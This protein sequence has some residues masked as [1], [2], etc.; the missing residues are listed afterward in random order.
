MSDE[1][2]EYVAIAQEPQSEKNR[3]LALM[4]EDRR[5]PSVR[6]AVVRAKTY[7]FALEMADFIG[8]GPETDQALRKLIEAQDALLRAAR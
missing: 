4:S 8:E 2:N 3:L 7:A 5:S 6:E 1:S